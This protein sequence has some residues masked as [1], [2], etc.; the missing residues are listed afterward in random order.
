MKNKI[1]KVLQNG[2]I[3]AKNS[4]YLLTLTELIFGLI[5]I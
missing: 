4:K 3:H 1:L 5:F 2:K